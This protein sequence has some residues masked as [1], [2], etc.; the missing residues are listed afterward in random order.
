MKVQVITSAA[1]IR[2]NLKVVEQLARDEFPN[3]DIEFHCEDFQDGKLGAQTVIDRLTDPNNIVLLDIGTT[4]KLDGV[5]QQLRCT[6]PSPTFN[7][8][9]VNDRFLVLNYS[10]RHDA[11][12]LMRSGVRFD[13]DREDA[14]LQPVPPK[15]RNS[16]LRMILFKQDT[17]QST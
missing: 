10:S 4:D 15:E 8:D 5:A 3:S 14:R 12:L 17:K 13:S 6:V 11:L 16:H 1:P 2:A 9:S 7:D